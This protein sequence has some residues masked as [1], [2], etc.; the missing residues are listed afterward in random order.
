MKKLLAFVV[1]IACCSSSTSLLAE[2]QRPNKEAFK[3]RMK[4]FDTDGDGK[5]SADEKAAMKAAPGDRKPPGKLA[6][7]GFG[8]ARGGE[9]KAGLQQKIL[10]K[11][12]ANGNGKLDPDEQAAARQAAAER[13]KSKKL[14]QDGAANGA[15]NGGV[16]PGDGIGGLN[17]QGV[18]GGAA[19]PRGDGRAKLMERFDLNRDGQ[20]SPEEMA[21]AKAMME[22]L[23]G[24][25]QGG[26]N[27]PQGGIGPGG[28]R[29][30]IK[31]QRPFRQ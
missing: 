16:N 5:L 22:K 26:L 4:Q 13:R 25:G 9:T 8:A 15:A 14:G 31:G 7:G 20:L 27:L 18:G 11:F 21:Q 2:G 30:N 10:E 23:G 12:D 28:G 1:A 6:A 3:E 29:P 17:G 24:A 19:G